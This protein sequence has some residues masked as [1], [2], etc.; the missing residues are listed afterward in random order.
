MRNLNHFARA[1]GRLALL[2]LLVAAIQPGVVM[3]QVINEEA[4]LVASA[5][6]GGNSGASVSISGDT[7]VVG[8][9]GENANKGAAYVFLRDPMTGWALQQTL[10]A[11]NGVAGDL[12]GA[13][14]SISGDNIAIG[15][16]GRNSGTGAVYTFNRSGAVWTQG[17]T[18]AA[19]GG[20]TGDALGYAVSIQGLTIVAGAPLSDIASKTDV[21]SAYVFTSLNGGVTWSQQYHIQVTTGQAKAGDHLGWSVA[22]SGN[23]ALIG[24]PDDDFGNKTDAGSVYVFVRNGA[25]WTKQTRINPGATAG[26]RVGS[27]VALFSNTAV[28][29]ADGSNSAK[30]AAYVYSRSGTSW[31]LVNAITATGGVNGDRFGASVAVSGPLVAVGAPLANGA[32]AFSGKGYMFGLVGATYQ[33]VATLVATDNAAGDNFAASASLDAGRALVGSPLATTGVNVDNGAAYVFLVKPATATTITN[34]TPATTAVGQSYTVSVTVATNPLGGGIPSGTVDVSD[35]NGGFCTVTLDATGAGSCSLASLS[36]GTLTISASYSGTLL[37]GASA[38][39]A[40]HT[41]TAANTTTTITGQDFNPS[42]VG[43]P[44]TVTV[45]VVPVP[46]GVGTPTGSVT[47]TDGTATCTIVDISLANSCQ[48]TF[49]AAGTTNLTATYAGDS[50][51]AGSTSAP[52]PHITNKANTTTTITGQDFDPSVVG[53]PVTVTVSVAV[54]APGAGTPTGA[55]TITDG[56]ATCTIPDISAGNSCTLTFNAVGTTFLTASYAGD[57]NFNLSVSNS[58][59]HTTNKADTTT[60]ITADTPDPSAVGQAVTVSVAV[61]PVSPG[62]GTPTGSVTITD[63]LDAATCTIADITTSSSCQLSLTTAGTHTLTAAYSGDSNFNLSG[64]STSHV[65]DA[66]LASSLAF[67]QQPS[68]VLRGNKL[69]GVTVQVLDGTGAVATSDNTTTITLSLTACGSPVTFGPVTVVNG[70]ATFTGV[71]PRFYTIASNLTVNATSSPAFTPAI[72]NSFNVVVNPDVIF[73]DGFDG[74]RL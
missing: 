12:F 74:C 66:S 11:S 29:G 72:S 6:A 62:A 26:T 68:D 53:Q 28:L 23:T 17:V 24:A 9:S 4:K 63:S 59:S 40:T 36:A 37:F 33:Q 7:A 70:V 65:V 34:I 15:A 55:V 47:V 13:S 69:N 25:V 10:T 67:G 41:V 48:L 1:I 3:A 61:A 42:V 50:G 27:A 56:T 45:S 18:L 39:T 2:L 5:L 31:N 32:G 14:V 57:V 54:V 22:L 73:A 30:G 19:T 43:Q 38:T 20:A 44:V 46:P 64:S 49:T 52:V 8:A 16:A 58:V 51:F 35:G 21:G 71:G 60:T